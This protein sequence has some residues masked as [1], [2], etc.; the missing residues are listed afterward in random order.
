MLMAHGEAMGLRV[1]LAAFNTV[2]EVERLLGLMKGSDAGVGT[3][4]V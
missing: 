1:S 3:A 4:L 2:E